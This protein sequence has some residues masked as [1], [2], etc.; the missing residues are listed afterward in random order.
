MWLETDSANQNVSVQY[1][2]PT[3]GTFGDM[4]E[5]SLWPMSRQP[6]QNCFTATCRSCQTREVSCSWWC[7][8]P[9]YRYTTTSAQFGGPQPRTSC[10]KGSVQPD[11]LELFCEERPISIPQRCSVSSGQQAHDRS[12]SWHPAKSWQGPCCAS[13]GLGLRLAVLASACDK[14][15]IS[16]FCGKLWQELRGLSAMRPANVKAKLS[17]CGCSDPTVHHLPRGGR[18]SYITRSSA[19]CCHH[20]QC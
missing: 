6:C 16:S 4:Q 11:S 14:Q 12:Q 10:E 9:L 5:C 13:H 18:G 8:R 15:P 1:L 7:C 17:N 2:R 3:L 19:I 20:S